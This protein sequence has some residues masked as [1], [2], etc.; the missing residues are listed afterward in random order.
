[1][2]IYIYIH[3][4]ICVAFNIYPLVSFVSECLLCDHS[5]VLAFKNVLLFALATH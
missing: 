3:V 4:Y 2:Y 5:I 1:M